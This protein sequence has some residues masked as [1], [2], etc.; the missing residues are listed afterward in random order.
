MPSQEPAKSIY[1]AI[2]DEL[3]LR[4]VRKAAVEY[5]RQHGLTVPIREQ[6]ESAAR[7]AR[8]GRRSVDYGRTWA[9]KITAHMTAS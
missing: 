5:A 9:L 6:V 3:R 4:E 8:Y 1:L 2:R 7:Y